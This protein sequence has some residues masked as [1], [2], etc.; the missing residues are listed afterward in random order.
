[1]GISAEQL[2]VGGVGVGGVGTGGEMRN[3]T[4]ARA[5]TFQCEEQ[6]VTT[7]NTHKTLSTCKKS[8]LSERWQQ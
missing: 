1:M 6:N 3:V 4:R 8:F 5:V 2:A 7:G